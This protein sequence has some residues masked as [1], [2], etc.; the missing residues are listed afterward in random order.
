MVPNHPSRLFPTHPYFSSLLSILSVERNGTESPLVGETLRGSEDGERQQASKRSLDPS[1]ASRMASHRWL[2][3]RTASTGPR[4]ARRSSSKATA[5]GAPLDAELRRLGTLPGAGA[6]HSARGFV[7][8]AGTRLEGD[9][10]GSVPANYYQTRKAA[11]ACLVAIANEAV[12]RRRL[13]SDV[14]AKISKFCEALLAGAVDLRV[15]VE[16]FGGIAPAVGYATPGFEE[17]NGTW[18][19]MASRAD[20]KQAL[21]LVL[22]MIRAVH[23]PLLDLNT[24]PALDFGLAALLKKAQHINVDRL[25]AV[26]EEAFGYFTHAFELYRDSLAADK[27]RLRAALAAAGWRPAERGVKDRVLDGH[28]L[29]DPGRLQGRPRVQPPPVALPEALAA[30]RRAVRRKVQGLQGRRRQ[31]RRALPRARGDVARQARGQQGARTR[32]PRLARG[33]QAQPRL[34]RGGAPRHRG[35]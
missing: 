28:R 8:S 21:A 30:G 16:L 1:S 3:S 23:V 7:A 4:R 32:P 2:A 29:R 19:K 18:G 24:T 5:R 13:N 31:G 11:L 35:R 27:P 14:R 10:Q 12:G 15:A 34:R 22:T 33:R 25:V 20:I 17:A 26:L 6:V 9:A